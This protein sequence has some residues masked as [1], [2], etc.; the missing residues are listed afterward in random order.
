[1]SRRISISLIAVALLVGGL[2]CSSE[3]RPA[4]ASNPLPIENF[5]WQLTEIDGLP[6]VPAPADAPVASFRLDSSDKHVTGSTGL[7]NFNGG[8]ELNGKAL[9]FGPQ[10]MT[11][12]AGPQPL[13]RQEAAFT[14]ALTDTA[15]WRYFGDNTIDLLNAGDVPLARFTRGAGTD[16][17]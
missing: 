1:M 7:N 16:I 8:Y 2:S 10:A 12:M 4:C 11:R 15:S 5:T 9:T 17:K 14:S 6:V 13:M 3:S